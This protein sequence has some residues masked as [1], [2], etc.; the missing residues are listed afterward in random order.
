MKMNC[1][2]R[3]KKKTQTMSELHGVCTCGRQIGTRH[4]PISNNIPCC[5]YE[6]HWWEE[7]RLNEYW[8]ACGTFRQIS[9]TSKA[10]RRIRHKINQYQADTNPI[11][12]CTAPQATTINVSQLPTPSFRSARFPGSCLVVQLQPCGHWS[13]EDSQNCVW[14]VEDANDQVEAAS[15]IKR[16]FDGIN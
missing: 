3:P 14:E 15:L 10:P 16:L 7:R 8:L 5:H 9:F 6:N 1:V 11:P 13:R 12:S 4:I 2:S